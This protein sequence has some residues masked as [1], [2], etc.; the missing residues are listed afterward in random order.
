MDDYKE[1]ETLKQQVIDLELKLDH[2]TESILKMATIQGM[3]V[4]RLGF[5]EKEYVGEID[6]AIV[7]G[8]GP[9]VDE[10]TIYQIYRNVSRDPAKNEEAS[11]VDVLNARSEED[12][13]N[14]TWD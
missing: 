13:L 11:I 5:K 12:K 3:L 1:M 9:G 7:D 14:S 6:N 10:D 4:D 8:Y 2:L